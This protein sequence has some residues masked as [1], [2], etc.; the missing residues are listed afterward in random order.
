MNHTMKPRAIQKH[1][2]TYLHWW[3]VRE[4]AEEEGVP[5]KAARMM[6]DADSGARKYLHGRQKP[7]YLRRVVLRLFGLL[8]ESGGPQAHEIRLP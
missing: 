4:I 2:Q 8:D 1:T 7:L 6:T 3:Q 5:L